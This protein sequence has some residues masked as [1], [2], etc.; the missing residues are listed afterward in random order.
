MNSILR[1]WYLVIFK[2]SSLCRT[3]AAHHSRARHNA[4]IIW[5]IMC[6]ALQ[7]R[8]TP[9]STCTLKIKNSR[10]QG[11]RPCVLIFIR[12]RRSDSAAAR[13]LLRFVL[14]CCDTSKLSSWFLGNLIRGQKADFEASRYFIWYWDTLNLIKTLYLSIF[15]IVLARHAF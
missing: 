15:L 10:R 12:L 9:A 1:K 7:N 6:S 11:S 4:T 8:Q 2:W 13:M 5:C 3:G 14:G